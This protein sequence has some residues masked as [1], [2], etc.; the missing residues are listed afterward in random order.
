MT[1]GFYI[2]I[3][4]VYNQKSQQPPRLVQQI[5]DTGSPIIE[6]PNDPIELQRYD[7]KEL[8]AASGTVLPTIGVLIEF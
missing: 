1:L 6:N 5:D 8:S 7:L 4:N 2:D 3:Q